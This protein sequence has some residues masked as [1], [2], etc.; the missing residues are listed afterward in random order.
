M[1]HLDISAIDRWANEGKSLL[2][3]AS[4][5]SKVFLMAATLA[6]IIL[7]SALGILLGIYLMV[8]VLI[9]LAR[10][11]L[12]KTMALAAYPAVFALLFAF[13]QMA[14]G[15]Q[16]PV[17]IVMKAQAAA[18]T[19]LLLL[20]TT[21]YPQVFGLISHLMPK[22]LSD[23]LFLTYR[24]FFVLL[25]MI[26]RFLNA[27]RL[28]GGLSSLRLSTNLRNIA[29]GLGRLLIFS[30][31][32]SQRLYDVMNLRGYR[33]EIVRPAKL[34]GGR[35]DWLPTTTG[36]AVLTSSILWKVWN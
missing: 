25:E 13:S 8:L 15:W 3:L 14:G 6:S 31:E 33:G 36:I 12:L 2:H 11:P 34:K 5:A 28:R 7:T 35:H 17:I 20:G 30:Y 10:L 23:S 9:A 26:D 16:K 19:M 21:S 22:I 1:A 32:K 18:L 24:L 29:L 4:P 27:I